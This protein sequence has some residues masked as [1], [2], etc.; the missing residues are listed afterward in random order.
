MEIKD[1]KY[2]VEIA[3]QKS[4]RKAAAS[5]Y[6]SQP[7]LT[8]AIHNLEH[9]F[10]SALLNRTNKGVEMT[11]F[12]EGFYYYAKSILKQVDE[13]SKIKMSTENYIESRIS[14][15]IGKLI[16]RDDMIFQYYETIRARRTGIHII[17]TT[18]EDVLNLVEQ[19]KADI[20]IVTIN[21]M[22]RAAFHKLTE[23]KELEMHEIGEGTLYIH[24]GKKNP[25]YERTTIDAEELLPYSR[26]R[27][28]LDFFANINNSTTIDGKLQVSDFD[29]TIQMNNYHAIINMVKRT[30]SFIFGNKWQVE[31]LKRGQINSLLLNHCDVY[32][33]LIWI[34]RKRE[35]LS[36]QAEDFLKLFMDCYAD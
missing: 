18:I 9:E 3:E 35:I 12:G 28:P 25:F 36:P 13:I 14:I 20:G 8:R 32:Q 11:T 2:F 15:A 16:M 23:L 26:V 6:V 29:K 33:K 4:M 34:K 10:G 30:E 7:N 21:N 22:Q 1:L 17:E 24:L 31:E 27:L 19:T 5:L